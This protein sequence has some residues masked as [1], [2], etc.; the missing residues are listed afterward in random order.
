MTDPISSNWNWGRQKR[1]WTGRLK[2][3]EHLRR[4][5]GG[6]RAL[7]GGRQEEARSS[8][9]EGRP[10]GPG[11]VCTGDQDRQK[12]GSTPPTPSHPCSPGR[13]RLRAAPILVSKIMVKYTYH[14]MGH[15]DRVKCPGQW[16]EV[17]S[18]CCA[19]VTPDLSLYLPKLKLCPLK[20]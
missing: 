12:A 1:Q 7:E 6:G 14:Q 4:E 20:H 15:A 9:V 18:H 5:C 17:H 13:P 19:T 2:T 3:A 8:S 16:H 11:T 10:V